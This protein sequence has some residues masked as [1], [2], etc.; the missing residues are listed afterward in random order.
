MLSMQLFPAR[1]IDALHR[2]RSV[3]SRKEDDAVTT[4]R[5]RTVTRGTCLQVFHEGTSIVSITKAN[6]EY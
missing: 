5:G 2:S 3:L 4:K 6:Y 1:P